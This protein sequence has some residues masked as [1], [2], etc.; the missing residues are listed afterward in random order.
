M[1]AA[2][3]EDSQ[4]IVQLSDTT[5]AAG[6]ADASSQNHRVAF[7]GDTTQPTIHVN[8]NQARKV[9]PAVWCQNS[10]LIPF[11]KARM[12]RGRRKSEARWFKEVLQTTAAP[13]PKA[14]ELSFV[15]FF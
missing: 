14:K 7:S 15:P 11:M 13:S 2:T 5:S 12:N 3:D 4:Q 10:V 8:I 6:Q 1:R 9:V